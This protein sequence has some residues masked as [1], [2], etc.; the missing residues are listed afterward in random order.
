[1][2]AADIDVQKFSSPEFDKAEAL[3][4]K[5][6]QAAEEKAKIL[7]PYALDQ[8]AWNEYLAKRD[9]RKKGAVGV[10]QVVRVEGTSADSEQKIETF[11]Q[12]LVGKRI[13]TPTL[14]TYLTRLTGV[15]QFESA[16]YGLTHDGGEVGILVTVR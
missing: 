10:L 14:D 3:I 6:M 2:E 4:Q 7:Q 11:L 15:G 9:A 5:G 16:S 8:A 12:P 1:M 13:D